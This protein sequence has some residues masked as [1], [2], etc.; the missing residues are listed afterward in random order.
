[1]TTRSQQQPRRRL[2]QR[3]GSIRFPITHD[4]VPYLVTLS[5]FDDGRLAE[6]FLLLQYGVSASHSISGPFSTALA[7]FDVGTAV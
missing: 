2:P 6:V 7:A 1:M 5:L 4:N 3:R